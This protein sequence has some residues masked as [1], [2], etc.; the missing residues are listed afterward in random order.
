[1]YSM[2]RGRPQSASALFRGEWV[3]NDEGWV[4]KSADMGE[5]NV[6]NSKKVLRYFM[7]GP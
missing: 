7:D 4:Y 5:G 2:Y 6:K 1:M 3:K